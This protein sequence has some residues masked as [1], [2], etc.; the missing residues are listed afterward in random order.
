MN[1]NDLIAAV[2]VSS[3]LSKADAGKATAA[4]FDAIA[5]ALKNGGEVRLMGFGGFSVANRAGRLGRNPSTGAAI[6]IPASRRP[7]FKAGKVLK[8][9]VN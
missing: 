9:A 1:K 7:R 2:A 3:G 5:D 6:Q 4:V 8:N